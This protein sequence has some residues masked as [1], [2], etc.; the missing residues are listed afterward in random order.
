VGQTSLFHHRINAN[1]IDAVLAEQITRRC[2]D[3]L[4]GFRSTVTRFGQARPPVC[5]V[6]HI[7]A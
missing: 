1:A 2:Q 7:I 3:T 6:R 5:D 4:T